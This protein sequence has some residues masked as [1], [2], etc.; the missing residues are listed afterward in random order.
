MHRKLVRDDG[1]GFI[2]AAENVISQF[3]T[4]GEAFELR[5]HSGNVDRRN[6]TGS[7]TAGI[8]RH[9]QQS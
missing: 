3:V 7:P 1:G 4:S 9:L 2:D 6:V 8:D 5:D